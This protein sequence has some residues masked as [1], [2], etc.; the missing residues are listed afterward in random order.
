M[1]LKTGILLLNLGGPWSTREVKPFL[2]RIFSNPDILV[3]VPTPFRQSLAFLISQIKGPASIR[4]YEAIGGGSPQLHWTRLQAEGLEEH[5]RAQGT[6]EPICV[7]IGMQA[8]CPSI[9]KALYD[10][11]NQG[12]ERLVLLPLFP[13][14]STTTTGSCFKEVYK[15]LKRLKWAP[16]IQEIRSW[17]DHSKYI[18][19]LKQTL[20][21]VLKTNETQDSTHL[22]F[23]AHSLPLAIIKRGDPYPQEVEKT[24]SR[25]RALCPN[26]VSWS[27][28]FQSR[29][30]RMPWLEPYLE[31]ELVRLGKSGL[32]RLIVM[33]ISFVSD[34]IETLWELD[35]YYAKLAR[36]HG[37]EHYIRTR[38]FN[39]DPKFASVLH[40]LVTEASG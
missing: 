8:S 13:Q 27:L 34:H 35:L 6:R 9:Q 3:G 21:E 11:K 38:T 25:L 22:I 26:S 33:P 20:D 16:L 5:F 17:P 40:S 30:G 37:I 32:K 31:D 2:Y 39:D 12:A 7:S 24:V 29:N 14:Y 19:L 18:S 10:L 36:K 23:S 15:Q 28:A 1:N 4:S